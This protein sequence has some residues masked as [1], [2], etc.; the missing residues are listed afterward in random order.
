[1]NGVVVRI[2]DLFTQRR[3]AALDRAAGLLEEPTR[4]SDEHH[5][6][7]FDGMELHGMADAALYVVVLVEHADQSVRLV[8]PSL[9]HMDFA[10]DGVVDAPQGQHGRSFKLTHEQRLWWNTYIL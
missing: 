9:C 4:T 2:R 7:V 6:M 5:G 8:C 3:E 10:L 1:M